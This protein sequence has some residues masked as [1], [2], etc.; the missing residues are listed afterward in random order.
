ML[1]R[2]LRH[3][4]NLFH[5]RKR[6]GKGLVDCEVGNEKGSVDLIEC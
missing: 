3:A 4:K 5:K 2:W 1:K 6:S